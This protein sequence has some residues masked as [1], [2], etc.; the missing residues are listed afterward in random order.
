MVNGHL[1]CILFCIATSSLL[2]SLSASQSVTRFSNN[3]RYD[4]FSNPDNSTCSYNGCVGG[5]GYKSCFDCC[6]CICNY[7]SYLTSRNRCVEN[8]QVSKGYSDL[9]L[10]SLLYNGSFTF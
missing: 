2:R 10:D 1:T 7:G 8:N 3:L 9:S 6:I 5:N 4:E